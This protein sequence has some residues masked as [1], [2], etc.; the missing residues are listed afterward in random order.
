MEEILASIRRIISEDSGADEP[1]QAAEAAPPPAAL[2]PEPLTEDDIL[3]LTEALPD[4]SGFE[5]PEPVGEPESII[6]PES[7]AAPEPVGE[8]EPAPAPDFEDDDI[9]FAPE[10][11][12]EPAPAPV[13][14]PVVE[15]EPA[16]SEP[17]AAT[18]V[19][20]RP[21]PIDE[22][23]ADFDVEEPV[24]SAAD[25]AQNEA[26]SL[27]SSDAETAASAAFGALAN[28]LIT[29]SG[30][31]RTLEDIVADMLRPMLKGWLDENLPSLVE[32]LVAEEI[33]RV[34]RRKR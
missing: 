7:I 27:L 10:P 20:P 22:P 33:E 6:E 12:P 2:E 17:V 26:P 24:M 31:S 3:E 16:A 4:D 28:S 13:Y 5:A 11:S 15:A 8:P 23:E 1:A 18:G 19:A 29:S 14:E 30:G 32:R 34:A 25:T 9:G 21:A